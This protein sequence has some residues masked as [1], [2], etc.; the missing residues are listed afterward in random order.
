MSISVSAFA[1]CMHCFQAPGKEWHISGSAQ[2]QSGGL[3]TLVELLASVHVDHKS[4]AGAYLGLCS[5]RIGWE[6]K[7]CLSSKLPQSFGLIGAPAGKVTAVVE[8]KCARIRGLARELRGTVQYGSCNCSVGPTATYESRMQS[9]K[10]WQ[11]IRYGHVR[12]IIA[13]LGQV[14]FQMR[15]ESFD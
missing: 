13:I 3:T 6:P 1:T 4:V 14:W 5:A 2:E 9:S 11:S 12:T 15:H 10:I 8:D 7:M